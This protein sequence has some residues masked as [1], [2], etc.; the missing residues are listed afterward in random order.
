MTSPHTGDY[1]TYEYSYSEALS[2]AAV[3]ERRVGYGSS[4]TSAT[5]A[6]TKWYRSAMSL[7]PLA[8]PGTFDVA[9]ALP[10]SLNCDAAPGA[11]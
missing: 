8:K 4:Y 10:E 5:V 7:R 6:S 3:I 1:K 9:I 11:H 2:K